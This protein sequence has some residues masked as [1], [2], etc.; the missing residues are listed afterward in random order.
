MSNSPTPSPASAASRPPGVSPRLPHSH[1]PSTLSAQT[2]R[3]PG[4][5]AIPSPRRASVTSPT[6]SPQFHSLAQGRPTH[7]SN[8]SQD[9]GGGDQ[10]VRQIDE[11]HYQL[12]AL[13]DT[14]ARARLGL[15]QE[16]VEVFSVVE[17]FLVF[18]YF[19][20]GFCLCDLFDRWV[21]VR[22]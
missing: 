13:S 6:S 8:G 9:R 11:L 10:L 21:V 14:I 15:V 20:L 19:C 18:T 1:A 5:L 12:A 22:L 3:P 4:S 16:L 17:V 7:V 2:S